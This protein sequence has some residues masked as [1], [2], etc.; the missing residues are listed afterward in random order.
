MLGPENKRFFTTYQELGITNSTHPDTANQE[1]R[2]RGLCAEAPPFD[3]A[4]QDTSRSRFGQGYAE[5]LEEFYRIEGL[6]TDEFYGPFGLDKLL[7]MPAFVGSF[8]RGHKRLT[9]NIP[10]SDIDLVDFG[11]QSSQR[12]LALKGK[13]EACRLG[14]ALGLATSILRN[15]GVVLTRQGLPVDNGSFAVFNDGLGAK[16]RVFPPIL[17]ISTPVDFQAAAKSLNPEVSRCF[18]EEMAFCMGL[19][20]WLYSRNQN[21][22]LGLIRSILHRQGLSA[23]Q[24]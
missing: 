20:V 7:G 10:D 12:S 19:K 14:F 11:S 18:K 22:N 1:G 5:G 2:K 3:L 24:E 4:P 9:P 15:E 6:Q 17:K 16:P 13:I 21:V 8:I 23:T